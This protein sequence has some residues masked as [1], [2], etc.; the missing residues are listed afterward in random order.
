MTEGEQWEKFLAELKE[1]DKGVQPISSLNR[2]GTAADPAY[3]AGD[4]NSNVSPHLCFSSADSSDKTDNELSKAE[5][6]YINKLLNTKLVE[7]RASDIEMLREDPSNP[8]HSVKTFQD[9]K[10]LAFF[11][12][13]LLSIQGSSASKGYCGVRILQALCHSGKSS[14]LLNR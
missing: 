6:S 11:F 7:T 12:L 1:I 10:L 5:K 4:T 13:T 8:L 9:L 3:P 2:N 14:S